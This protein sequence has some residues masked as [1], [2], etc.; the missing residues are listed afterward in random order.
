[1]KSQKQLSVSVEADLLIL[2]FLGHFAWELLQAPL[3]SS[4]DATAHFAGILV[5]L[6]ATFGDL[7]IALG[8]FWC[9]AWFGGGRAWVARPTVGAVSLFIGFGLVVTIGLEFVNTEV[10]N[11][12]SYGPGMPRMPIF[13]TGL[14]PLL[15]WMIVPALVLWYLKR[16]TKTQ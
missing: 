12:W 11:R 3:F 7:G 4:L 6:R 14:A 8:A 13:G 15:Q 9:A 1:M 16:L 5:C 2:S 10:L